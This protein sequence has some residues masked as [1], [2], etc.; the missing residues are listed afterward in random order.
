MAEDDDKDSKTEDPS[1]KRLEEAVGRGQTAFSREVTSFLILLVLTLMIVSYS[2][3]ML[4]KSR[5]VLSPFITKV[6]DIPVERD[7]I[8]VEMVWLLQ[9]SMMIIAIPL[10]GTV[11][12]ALSSR[13]LQGGFVFTVDPLQPKLERIS[14]RK[15]LERMFSMRSIIELLKGIFKI[16]IVG[17]IAFFAVYYDIDPIRQLAASEPENM[18]ILLQMLSSRIL[19]GVTAAVG[20]I[21][22]IDFIYQKYEYIKSLRMTKQEVKDEYKQQEGDPMIKQRL[23]QIRTER[24]RNRM[25]QEVPK[26][27]VV[28]TNP[29]HY[30][31]ALQYEM[32]SMEAPKIVAKGQDYIALKIK[33]VAKENNIPI[34]EN[35]TLA[36]ALFPL[37]LDSTIPFQHFKA[38]AEI[39]SYV[40]KLKKK[41][42]R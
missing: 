14:L 19:I 37:D 22:L 21:A 20:I 34:V 3:T 35:P 1:S 15:G 33:E 36:R 32:A 24:A 26:S 6:H 2:P 39:I 28:I 4:S 23:R 42:V 29:T 40:Y 31:V 41:K 8:G 17:V 9:S 5:E 38:V 16:A 30:A 13:M 7:I 10:L 11:I 27:D 12:V 25:M 18:L